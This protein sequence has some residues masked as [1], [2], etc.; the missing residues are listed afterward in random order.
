MAEDITLDVKGISCTFIYN[1]TSWIIT[2][3]LGSS[4]SAAERSGIGSV[5]SISTN[6]AATTNIL[7]VLTASL[8]L[9]LPSAPG[10]GATVY[11]TNRSGTTT[12]TLARNGLKIMGLAEDMT[13]DNI[14][15]SFALVYV[16]NTQDWVIL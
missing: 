4:V 13:I 2:T 5:Q 8:I 11:V 1:G 10:P 6:T 7:Y 16:D 3:H 12:C 9:T 15:A 14:N